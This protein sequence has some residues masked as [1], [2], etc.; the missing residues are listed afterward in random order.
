[1]N[2]IQFEQFKNNAIIYSNKYA[3]FLLSGSKLLT[4]DKCN[5]ITD[6]QVYYMSTRFKTMQ[7]KY[8]KKKKQPQK[9]FSIN[10]IYIN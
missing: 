1:M 3:P 8:G 2:S 9:G 5:F 6:A 10:K 4:D 7:V